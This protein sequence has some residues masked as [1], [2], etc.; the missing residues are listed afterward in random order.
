[1]ND[2]FETMAVHV[3]MAHGGSRGGSPVLRGEKR[4]RAAA[5]QDAGAHGVPGRM[6]AKGCRII[7]TALNRHV[8]SAPVHGRCNARKYFSSSGIANLP[9]NA[10]SRKKLLIN[11]PLMCLKQYDTCFGLL[12]ISNG[13]NIWT[14][15]KPLLIDSIAKIS[16]L[17]KP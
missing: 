4:R 6:L 7:E 14:Q 11:H 12:N 5:V 9:S 16:T 17:F 2:F 1:V 10:S 8:P 3:A 15:I 13:F